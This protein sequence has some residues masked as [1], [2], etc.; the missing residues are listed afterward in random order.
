MENQRRMS[1]QSVQKTLIVFKPDAVQ[2]G[3]VGEILTRFERVGLKIVATKMIAPTKEHYHTHYEEI[4]KMITRRGQDTFDITLE[5]MVQGPVI[6]MVLEGVEAVELVRKL[7][8][9]TEPKSALPGTIRGDFSHMSF[10]YADAEGKGIPNL[11]HAS[12][13]PDEA[14]EEINHWFSDT[15]LY[16]YTSLNEKFTR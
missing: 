14:A 9:T 8:G 10:G 11:I 15:E 3:I 1:N 5:M 13:D 4:G 7:V 12:G 2:R 16:D 6:A